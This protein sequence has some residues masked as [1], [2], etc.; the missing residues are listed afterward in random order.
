MVGGGM[1]PGCAQGAAVPPGGGGVAVA[2][3]VGVDAALLAPP[4]G[5]DSGSSSQEN[6]L[7]KGKCW[8]TGNLDR[9]SALNILIMPLLILPQPSLT[10]EISNSMGLCSQKGP[11]LISLINPMAE[12][13][14]FVCRSSST[15][16][17][18]V[19][20]PVLGAPRTDPSRGMASSSLMA[21]VSCAEPNMYGANEWS[22]RPQTP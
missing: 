2:E 10:P 17:A 20:S 11:F 6:M 1:R 22:S 14:M 3:C 7:P 19:M 16:A 18:F 13:Y 21:R 5:S 8:T 9:T 12:K 4:S 15:T